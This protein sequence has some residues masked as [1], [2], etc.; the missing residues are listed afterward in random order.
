MVRYR[1]VLLLC[2]FA[3][4]KSNVK[5][6]IQLP[7]AKQDIDEIVRLI[8][9]QDSLNNT[10]APLSKDLTKNFLAFKDCDTVP[11]IGQETTNIGRLL[12]EQL[13]NNYFFFRRDSS[14]LVFQNDVIK[15]FRIDNEF[16]KIIKLTDNEEVTRIRRTGQFARYYEITLPLFSLDDK[17][18]FVELTYRCPTCGYALTIFL[19]KRNGKWRILHQRADWES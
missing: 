17:K 12:R 14:Y 13:N 4:C 9:L 19:E 16:L 15:S 8:V 1:L 7:P 5:R 18:A 11:P 6:Q 10:G 2:F 3:A